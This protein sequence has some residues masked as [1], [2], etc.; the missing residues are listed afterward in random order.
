MK[1]NKKDNK[2]CKC[3]CTCN[4]EPEQTI[5]FQVSIGSNNLKLYCDKI[6]SGRNIDGYLFCLNNNNQFNYGILL[7]SC[8]VGQPI[9][10]VREQMED[11]EQTYIVMDE[12][13]TNLNIEL[14]MG[15]DKEAPIF[16]IENGLIKENNWYDWSKN[17][18]E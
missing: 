17:K 4:K 2:K 3:T 15:D 14:F 6:L 11:F 1:K 5:R 9:Y 7:K 18:N 16:I 12:Y 8:E 10:L 13:N